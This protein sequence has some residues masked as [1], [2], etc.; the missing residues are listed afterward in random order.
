MLVLNTGQTPWNT[1]RQ[2]EVI[3]G[4]LAKKIEA[5]LYKK[6]PELTSKIDILGVDE[7]RNRTQAGKYHK[8]SVIE[9]YLGFNT[10]NLKVQVSD[11]LSEEY[12]RFD[13]LESID[14][15]DSIDYF[16]T[17]LGI[18]G[19]LDYAFSNYKK[20]ESDSISEGKFSEEQFSKDQFLEGKDIF[21]SSPACMGFIVASAEY[22]LG[23]KSVTRSGEKINEKCNQY[24]KQMDI[25]INRITD[26]QH[27]NPNFLGLTTL[28]EISSNLP[29]SRIGDEM[30]RLFRDAFLGMLK[31][32]E[33]DEIDSMD[34]FWRE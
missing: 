7:R 9:M 32:E 24:R 6:F 17:A 3:Y 16:V 23:K 12:Q 10:R 4:N 15:P 26:E 31:N 8:S 25:I 29:K 2:I 21:A 22:I 1:R 13:V 30:R 27:N 19:K 14:E 28:N 20:D 18:M 5:S 33:F 11:E 34:D